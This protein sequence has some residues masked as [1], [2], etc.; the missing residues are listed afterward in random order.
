MIQSGAS[1]HRP[2]PRNGRSRARTTRPLWG[3]I[4]AGGEGV[5]LRQLTHYLCGEERPKQYVRVLGRRSLLRQTLDRM[6]LIIPA[7]R[8]V[9]VVHRNHARFIA[10]ELRGASTP[11]LLVQS[12]DRG[13]AGAVLLAA[14]WISWRSPEALIAILPS[15]HFVQGEI[16]F[17][18][19]VDEV[20][21]FIDRQN[22]AQ[23]VLLGA[24]PT[25]PDPQYGWIETGDPLGR[26]GIDPILRVRGFLE[27]PHEEIAQAAWVRGDLWNT[28]VLVTAVASLVQ[29]GW[30]VLPAVSD[31]LATIEPF[32][33]TEDEESA[34]AWAY[35]TMPRADF[36]RAVLERIPSSLA[37]VRLPQ[38]V[39]WSDW[40]TPERV[41]RSLRTAGITPSWLRGLGDCDTRVHAPSSPVPVS[42]RA[43]SED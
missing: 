3:V 1:R 22:A 35:A 36:S 28:A 41:I 12:D 30:T 31:R 43:G 5:R 42:V 7:D 18:D 9:V 26:I 23:L 17:M 11:R 2:L 37:T 19:R 34:I 39:L 21:A 4:L 15:D 16:G 8:T 24:V 14:Q 25:E 29:A 6:S 32:S 20:A 13:T 40:G 33:D 27:K 10:E 38:G